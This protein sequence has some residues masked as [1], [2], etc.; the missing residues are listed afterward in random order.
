MIRAVPLGAGVMTFKVRVTTDRNRTYI[1]RIYPRGREHVAGFEPLLLVRMR[2]CGA[3]VPEVVSWSGPESALPHLV[4]EMIPGRSLDSC[5][6]LLSDAELER[7]C[8]LLLEQLALVSRLSV[9]GFGELRNAERARS[10]GWKDFIGGVVAA[11]IA[12]SVP[13]RHRLERAR[14]AL[15]A[16][17]ERRHATIVPCLVWT[18]ISPENV[19]V[20]EKGQFAGLIDFEGAMVLERE[21]T[22]GYLEARYQGTRFHRTCRSLTT[23]AEERRGLP[24]LYAVVRALRL[25]PYLERALPTGEARD[26]LD[27]FLPGLRTACEELIEWG[28][29][30]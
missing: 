10:L 20:D 30:A 6:A 18:D 27:E 2:G 5:L 24:A 3:A 23:L 22:L 29:R 16:V 8:A 11:P 1:V 28:E 9:D 14:A 15:L 26:R 17:S 4:Y 12:T 7:I 25:Q 13:D 19:I 21:A